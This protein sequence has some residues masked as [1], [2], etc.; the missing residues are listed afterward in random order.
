[1]EYKEIFEREH[2]IKILNNVV[3]EL[4]FVLTRNIKLKLKSE[5]IS[6]MTEKLAQEYFSKIYSEDVK[7]ASCDN[8]PDLM[9]GNTPV[10]IKVAKYCNG[11]CWRGGKYS[12]R[13]SDYVLIVWDFNKYNPEVIQF[14]VYKSF[15]NKQDW[16]EQ[17][18]DNYYA[19]LYTMN[20]LAK[21]KTHF[22]IIGDISYNKNDNANPVFEE[23]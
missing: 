10:E 17:K 2:W 22:A 5:L 6:E 7:C 15:L 13:E 9:F 12:K 20:A 4:Q 16:V 8:D 11:F 21:N 14:A 19:T 3:E 23:I 1:M 18:R